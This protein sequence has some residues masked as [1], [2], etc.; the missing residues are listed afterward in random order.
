[1]KM[2]K[3]FN[4]IGALCALYKAHNG[5][6]GGFMKMPVHLREILKLRIQNTMT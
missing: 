5:D 3:K 6:K 1:M 4:R 2:F